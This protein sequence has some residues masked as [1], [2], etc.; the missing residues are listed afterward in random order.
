V[1]FPNDSSISDLLEWFRVEVAAMPIAFAE[2][3]KNT[4][5]YALIGIF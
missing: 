1:E 3:N 5:C 2:C 4:T